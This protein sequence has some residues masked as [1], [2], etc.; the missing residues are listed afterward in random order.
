MTAI[1]TYTNIWF[2]KNEII[3]IQIA[4]GSA[5]I[6]K[7]YVSTSKSKLRSAG[8]S[9]PGKQL[10]IIPN[11]EGLSPEEVKIKYPEYFL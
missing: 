3:Q 9:I 5:L 4:P 6:D 10:K 11:T 2:E 7:E 1:V 8:Y